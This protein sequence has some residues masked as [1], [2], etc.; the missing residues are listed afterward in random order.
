MVGASFCI[1]YID[2]KIAIFFD[3][4][5]KKTMNFCSSA[6]IEKLQLGKKD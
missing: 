3:L 6:T 4:D 2:K 5:A 1:F